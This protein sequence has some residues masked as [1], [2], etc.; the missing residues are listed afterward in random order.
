MTTPVKVQPLEYSRPPASRPGLVTAIGVLSIVI[1]GLSILSNLSAVIQGF[2]MLTAS[3]WMSA[4]TTTAPTTTTATTAPA[5]IT[6]ATS[7]PPLIPRI[8]A[9]MTFVAAGLG[10]ALAIYLLVIGILVFRGSPNGAR[11][12]MAY[13]WLKIGQC[14]LG[15]AAALWLW[16]GFM[17][18]AGGGAG[19]L[20]A[21]LGI[22]VVLPA[23]VGLAYP[24]G[25]LIALRSASVR[26]YYEGARARA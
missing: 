23:L 18:S 12:H 17:T 14:L 8:P 7:G 9:A 6:P 10:V 21:V 13:A 2:G 3:N 1:G 24:I 4:M 16:A 15:G 25:L 11:Q 19:A 20:S 22:F 26:A 5:A